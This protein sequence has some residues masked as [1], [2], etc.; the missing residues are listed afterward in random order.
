MIA[1]IEGFWK[2]GSI[3]SEFYGDSYEDFVLADNHNLII[4]IDD[5]LI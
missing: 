1:E 3:K 2:E 5:I 4:F